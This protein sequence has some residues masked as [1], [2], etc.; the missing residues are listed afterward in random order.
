MRSKVYFVVGPQEPLLG[1]C[2]RDGNLHGSGMSNAM[3][4]SQNHPS[5]HLGGW[6]TTWSVEEMLDGHHQRVDIP[7][8]AHMGL[9]R[10]RLEEDLG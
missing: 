4:A 7:A 1:N 10:K 9:L 2:Q 5:G 3:T 6:A 8:H